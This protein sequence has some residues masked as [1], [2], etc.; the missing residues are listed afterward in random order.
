METNSCSCASVCERTL[1]SNTPLS[2]T[3]SILIDFK[4]SDDY[5]TYKINFPNTI[6]DSSAR[7]MTFNNTTIQGF[8]LPTKL[9]KTEVE[10]IFVY[11]HLNKNDYETFVLNA[12][13]SFLDWVN[14]DST[15]TIYTVSKGVLLK[16]TFVG[17]DV[18]SLNMFDPMSDTGTA[19]QRSILSCVGHAVAS[20]GLGGWICFVA[21]TEMTLLAYGIDCAWDALGS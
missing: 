9:T 8:W 2:A 3:D 21:D 20:Q 4:N 14:F 7:M 15:S 1:R 5:T 16:A 19:N 13:G 11:F 18:M 12:N 6:I 10:V 17:K